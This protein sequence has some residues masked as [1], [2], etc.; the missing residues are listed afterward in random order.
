MMDHIV[1]EPPRLDATPAAAHASRGQ[2]VYG[3]GKRA[4]DLALV[5]IGGPFFLPLI[6]ILAMLIRLDGSPAFYLQP[7][8][9]RNGRIFRLWKLRTMVPDAD[10]ALEQYLAAN[11]AE[12]AEWDTTQKLRHD[13]RLTPL[14]RQLRRYSFD[15]LPQLWNVLIGDM[16]LVGPR[17]MMPSQRLLYHGTAY[18]DFRPG[19]TGLWQVSERNNCSFAERA[20][21]DNRY[22][23][24]VSLGTDL[25]VLMQTVGVVFR[26]T[27][28]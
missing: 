11:P 15:E 16:S 2:G 14:G 5:L 19:L 7:R 25:R 4:L 21:Y 10:T 6:L 13:P 3:V 20:G 24:T 27:G 18:F 23:Q 17:P 9:G 8:I 1:D 22:A 12:R 26:G 28:V